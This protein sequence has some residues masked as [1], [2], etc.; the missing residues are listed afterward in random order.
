[1]QLLDYRLHKLCMCI[2]AFICRLYQVS[3]EEAGL[4][5]GVVALAQSADW[6]VF[7]VLSVPAEPSVP[8]FG[9]E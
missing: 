7:N 5:Q 2:V 1:M 4:H 9:F 8:L 3:G 6:L